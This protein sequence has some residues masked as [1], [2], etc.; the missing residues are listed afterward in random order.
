MQGDTG[1]IMQL[2]KQHVDLTPNPP[3]EIVKTAH[4]HTECVTVILKHFNEG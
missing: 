1:T 2:A 3:V 4:S